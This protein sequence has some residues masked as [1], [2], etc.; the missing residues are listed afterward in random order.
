W[1][2]V[3]RFAWDATTR[4]NE[5]RGNPVR[6]RDCPAAVSENE[7]RNRHRGRTKHWASRP[8]KRRSVE[9]PDGDVGKRS[10]VRK[11]ATGPRTSLVCGGPR[12]RGRTGRTVC[13]K[14]T[15]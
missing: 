11:P 7:H 13:A 2:F 5:A 4:V 8:G 3:H 15:G 1:W 10:R 12:S 9:T 6:I 14:P